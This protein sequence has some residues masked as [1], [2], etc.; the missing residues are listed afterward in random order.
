MHRAA[1]HPLDGP[2]ALSRIFHPARDP[3]G[4]PGLA[5][6]DRDAFFKTPDGANLHARFWIKDAKLPTVVFF[7]GN[8]E[9]VS[10]YDDL[11]PYFQREGLNIVF[12]EYRGY[13]LSTGEPTVT[14]LFT[15]ALT[16]FDGVKARLRELGAAGKIIVMGRSLG[17]ACA[18]ELAAKRKSEID[19]LV[20]E[21]GF[22]FTLPLL[23]RLGLDA[24]ALGI[25]EKDGFLN[26]EKMKGWDKPLLVI[27]AERDDIIPISDARTLF[28]ASSSVRKTF[29]AIPD[30]GHNDIFV[31]ALDDYMDELGLLASKTSKTP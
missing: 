12:A 31:F 13:G 1:S 23:E 6:S 2:S 21:S 18:L 11:A 27:H 24:N 14:A 7:H 4:E 22:A 5:V 3:Q 25:S 10:D 8:G 17:S 16:L 9:I 15:D 30:A 20:I 19:A 26:L 28:K 29:L